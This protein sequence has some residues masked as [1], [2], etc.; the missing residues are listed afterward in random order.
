MLFKLSV[1]VT[2]PRAFMESCNSD[3]M[4]G[5]SVA[6]IDGE[7]RALILAERGVDAE[8]TSGRRGRRRDR[9]SRWRGPVMMVAP[10]EADDLAE[11]ERRIVWVLVRCVGRGGW[12]ARRCGPNGGR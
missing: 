7:G 12:S 5:F 3:E 6:G 4:E 11:A 2:S 10:E 1:I 9:L 8:K